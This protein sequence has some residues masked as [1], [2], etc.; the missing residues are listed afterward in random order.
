MITQSKLII[1]VNDTD[2]ATSPLANEVIIF[3][4]APP[5]AAAI[6]ITPTANSGDNG[7]N[8]TIINATNGK[9]II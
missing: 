9:I 7:H 8:I 6:N 5:G 3:E 2:N 4:V 1:A